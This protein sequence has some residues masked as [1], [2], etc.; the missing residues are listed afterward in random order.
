MHRL[1][2]YCGSNPGARPE[3]AEAAKALAV[4]MVR[5]DIGLVYGGGRVGIM[6]VVADAILAAGGEAIGVIPRHLEEREVGHTGL[7]ELHVVETMHQRKQ[8]MADLADGFI[9]LP[10]GIGTFEEIFEVWTWAQLGTHDK[11]VALLNAAGYYDKLIAFLDHVTDEMFVRK[12][13]RD[14]LQ[15]ASEPATLLDKL[16]TYEPPRTVKW[17]DHSEV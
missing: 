7:T 15:V 5:R 4:E 6:G 1:C 10:G 2:V 9:A 13:Q 17:L 16:R 14:M 3:Y 8:K 12:S 11:P